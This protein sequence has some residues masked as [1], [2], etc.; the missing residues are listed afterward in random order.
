VN[1]QAAQRLGIQT[2]E[3]DVRNAADVDGAF[4]AG[5]EW[6]AEGFLTPDRIA[7]VA[8]L[9]AR[10]PLGGQSTHHRQTDEDPSTALRAHWYL[11]GAQREQER[12]REHHQSQEAAECG[13]AG[14]DHNDDRK[15]NGEQ[16]Q[17]KARFPLAAW[18]R[19]D[20]E[21]SARSSTT[22]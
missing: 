14:R 17:P 9:G 10:N 20:V 6:G 15:D 16:H 18:P 3:L 19:W 2:L 4:Q 7:R 8:E 13:F 1:V 12:S 21:P 22:G 5:M 11:S